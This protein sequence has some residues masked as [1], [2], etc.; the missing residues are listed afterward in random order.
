[1]SFYDF[2]RMRAEE[3]TELYLRKVVIGENIAVGRVEVNEGAITHAH[4][5]D[6]EEMI[7]VLK[8]AWRFTLPNGEVTLSAN[9]M[10]S[11]PP[12]VRAFFR[13]ARKHCGAGHLRAR[14]S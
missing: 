4:R 6:N 9:Q 2:D 8:G 13:S 7:L 14:A 12:G 1:M 3:I 11:I 10:L 5:H